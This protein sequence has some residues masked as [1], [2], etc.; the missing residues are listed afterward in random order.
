MPE[1]VL[2]AMSAAH[3]ALLAASPPQAPATMD[4]A[5]EE[6]PSQHGRSA[7]APGEEETEDAEDSED[8]LMAELAGTD[9]GND[10]AMLAV[11]R[12]LRG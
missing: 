7:E 1:S 10:D 2:A 4:A 3:A 6:A 11:A 9:P 12:R 8:D 5:L